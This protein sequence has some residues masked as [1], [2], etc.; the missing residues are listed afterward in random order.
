MISRTQLKLII[1]FFFFSCAVGPDFVPPQTEVA[2]D[3]QGNPQAEN[4]LVK[5]DSKIDLEWWKSF[6]DPLLV[7]L[8]E[9]SVGENLDIKTALLQIKESRAVRDH[10]RADLFPSIE[11]NSEYKRDRQSENNDFSFDKSFSG[12]DAYQVGFDTSWEMDI[13]GKIRR[14][15]EAAKADLGAQEDAA[16]NIYLITFAEIAR[17]YLELRTFQKEK[18]IIQ[19]N[20][21][22]Q[23]K[24]LELVENKF[25]YG[26]ISKLDL[27][28]EQSLVNSTR[29]KLPEVETKIS[30][31]IHALS[32]LLGKEP[33]VLAEK[34]NQ[35]KEIPALPTVVQVGVPSEILRRR[36]DIRQA[37]KEIAAAT[38]RIGVATADL[39]PRFTLNGYYDLSSRNFSKLFN[40]TSGNWSVGPEISWYILSA[41]SIN[42]N[43]RIQEAKEQQSLVQYQ[44]TVL[45]ALK[46]VEDN[47]VSLENE[48]LRYQKLQESYQA[49]SESVVLAK[50]MYEQGTID[51][52]RLLETETSL[53]AA[54]DS[55]VQSEGALVINLLSLYKSLGGGWETFIKS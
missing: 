33:N 47:I 9:Q 41:K 11:I 31:K 49:S 20:I 52:I 25:K 44:K 22:L 16:K 38:A 50:Q 53:L 10:V 17:N 18:N 51:F 27:L 43:I 42:A 46:E 5:K 8:I 30:T 40:G 12:R 39:F 35:I 34:L 14:D 55:L 36:P 2:K 7:E 29:A 13:F 1:P 26:V 54:Q 21:A 32:I 6:N 15:I 28:R 24:S 48:R 3:W 19:E 4:A 37:E 23:E 45:N